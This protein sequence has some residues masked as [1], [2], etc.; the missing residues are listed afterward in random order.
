MGKRK[1]MRRKKNVEEEENIQ[2]RFYKIIF[3]LH[4]PPVGT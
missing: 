1:R 2:K 4:M 3:S